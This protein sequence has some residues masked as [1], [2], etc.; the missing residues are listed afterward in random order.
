M[1]TAT[2]WRV[3]P[4]EVLE[5]QVALVK[6]WRSKDGVMYASRWLDRERATPGREEVYGAG[7]EGAWV[8]DREA[9]AIDRADT[10]W[11]AHDM[12]RVAAKAAEAMPPEP[13]MESDPPSRAGFVWFD[14]PLVLTVVNDFEEADGDTVEVEIAAIAW[15]P[16][17]VVPKDAVDHIEMPA[18]QVSVYIH[19]DPAGLTPNDLL[20][21]QSTPWA[22]GYTYL[23]KPFSSE[24]EAGWATADWPVVLP[25]YTCGFEGC[26]LRLSRAYNH[27]RDDGSLRPYAWVHSR[28]SYPDIR[29]HQ[30]VPVP[31]EFLTARLVCD[32]CSA[33]DPGWVLGCPDFDYDERGQR[34]V[35]RSFWTACAE[36]KALIDAQEMETLAERSVEAILAD[37]SVPAKYGPRIDKLRPALI[38]E[39]REMHAQ[40]MANRTH[41]DRRVQEGD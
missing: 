5:H 1:T 37:E 12:M 39:M 32:F 20:L 36:C 33:L 24:P 41:Q 35:V 21:L 9:H 30:P 4:A 22:V 26:R 17:T 28:A 25:H 3:R 6:W 40:F 18:F 8:A 27:E 38:R 10:F 11:V 31:Q 19:G 16:V 14:R 7:W 29:Q 13:L 23:D 2:V 34:A 15:Y